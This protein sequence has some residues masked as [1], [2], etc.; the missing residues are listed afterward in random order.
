[1]RI[2][3]HNVAH[4]VLGHRHRADTG[5]HGAGSNGQQWMTYRDWQTYQNVV[6]PAPLYPLSS[7]ML[8]GIV[9]AQNGGPEVR[10]KDPA[11]VI[12]E[13]RSYFGSGTQLQPVG[14]RASAQ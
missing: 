3:D 9:F 5:R 13:I 4:D 2:G 1:M 12:D 11:D 8:H 14:Q 10:E 6:E 7:L